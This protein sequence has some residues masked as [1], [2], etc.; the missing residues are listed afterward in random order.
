MKIS[1]K[2]R[3]IALIALGVLSVSAISEE[4][5]DVESSE[6]VSKSSPWRMSMGVMRRQASLSLKRFSLGN[7]NNHQF[8]NG[9]IVDKGSG[10]WVYNVSHPYSQV[11]DSGSGDLDT[12]IMSTVSGQEYSTNDDVETGLN[13]KFRREIFTHDLFAVDIELGL[14][15]LSYDDDMTHSL[16]MKNY[17]YDIASNPWP[18]EPGNP[19]VPEDRPWV[20][21]TAPGQGILLPNL[22]WSSQ[23]LND[24]QWSMIGL[25]LGLSLRTNFDLPFNFYL[26]AGPTVGVVFY[27]MSR[28]IV[29]NYGGTS[30]IEAGDSDD[31]IDF[32]FGLY[33]EVGVEFELTEKWGLSMSFRYDEADRLNTDIAEVDFNG[34]S[35]SV[36]A[37]YTF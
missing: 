4:A 1:F 14:N 17:S 24:L 19:S 25:D 7:A 5:M 8:I 12:I 35:A 27:D 10:I 21:G 30:Y 33:T 34:K 28:D 16:S 15:A 23:S 31:G 2:K 36:M 20:P 6:M 32:V 3:N 37:T 11:S 22:P 18:T 13:F 9:S 26:S 29:V